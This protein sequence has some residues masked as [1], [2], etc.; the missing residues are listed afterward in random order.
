MCIR[1][2]Y[3][4]YNVTINCEALGN[5]KMVENDAHIESMEPD[6]VPELEVMLVR[7]HT[8]KCNEDQ[9]LEITPGQHVT[10]INIIYDS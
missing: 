10:P 6:L 2:R 3:K 7:Q 9:C 4:H 8:M 5:S 1:D